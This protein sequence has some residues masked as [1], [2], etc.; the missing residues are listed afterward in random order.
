MT[1]EPSLS[2]ASSAFIVCHCFQISEPEILAAI[3]NGAASISEVLA[4]TNA[5]GACGACAL[6]IERMLQGL[7]PSSFRCSRC[8][9]SSFLCECDSGIRMDIRIPA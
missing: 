5:T 8:G 2:S 3:H 1:L 4:A 7:P 6:S 9:D